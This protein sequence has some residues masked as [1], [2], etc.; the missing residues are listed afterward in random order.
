MTAKS[1]A[2]P[3]A[4]PSPREA[5]AIAMAGN[6][7]IS[8]ARQMRSEDMSMAEYATLHLLLAGSLR[9]NELGD[10]LARPLPAASRIASALVKRGLVLREEDEIDRRAKR[11]TLSKKGR[12][13]IQSTAGILL[14]DIGAALAQMNNEI[15]ATVLPM[16]E[17]LFGMESGET[18]KGLA[19]TKK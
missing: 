19:E 9:I 4:G 1:Q 14:A 12:L 11:L 6:T 7:I 5:Y 17:R 16:Y 2:N 18:P 3:K 8:L 15:A 10:K 13:L